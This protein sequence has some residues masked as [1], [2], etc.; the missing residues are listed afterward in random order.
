MYTVYRP[1]L[2]WTTIPSHSIPLS[3]SRPQMSATGVRT[4]RTRLVWAAGRRCLRAKPKFLDISLFNYCQC[5]A[6]IYLF[7]DSFSPTNEHLFH[8]VCICPERELCIIAEPRPLNECFWGKSL[9][10]LFYYACFGSF[11]PLH[12][13]LTVMNEYYSATVCCIFS[14][15]S[16]L[17]MYSF[18]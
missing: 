3:Q 10:C 1:M 7:C 9:L 13:V 14:L 18:N 17:Y 4:L 2:S 11:T 16:L 15:V 12:S 5:Y 8:A 6:I